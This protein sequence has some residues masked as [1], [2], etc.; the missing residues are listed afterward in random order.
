MS[1]D[2]GSKIRLRFCSP[3]A[4]NVGISGAGSERSSMRLGAAFVKNVRAVSSLSRSSDTLVTVAR[5]NVFVE[6][7][8]AIGHV[9][10]STL[11]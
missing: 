1:I 5:L 9:R 3:E 7:Y 6:L 8:P 10:I 11:P 4:R 2:S